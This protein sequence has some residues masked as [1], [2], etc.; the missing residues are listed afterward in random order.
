METT[1]LIADDLSALGIRRGGVLMVHS[2]LR[3]LGQVAGGAETVI[4][5]LLRALG[6]NGTLLMPALTYERV[7]PDHPVFDARLT[8]SNVGAIPEA[9]RQR[10][11]TLRSIHPTH[12]V[13]GY[14]P[15]AN[16]LLSVHIGDNTPCGLHSPFHTLPDHEGQILMLGCGLEPNTSMHA[17]EEMVPPPYLFAPPIDYDLVLPNG[18]RIKKNYI[19]HNFKGWIQRYDRVGEILTPPGLRHGRVL[20]AEAYLIETT[21]LWEKSLPALQQDPL[22]FVDQQVERP[23]DSNTIGR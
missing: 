7:T 9:F 22:H 19:P 23:A 6:K 18:E 11:G 5:G 17:I 2:S 15:L 21:A 14:G 13:C 12:S 1:G 3:S 10:P 20:E 16:A 4:Q 8:P